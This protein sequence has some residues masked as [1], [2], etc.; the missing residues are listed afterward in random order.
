MNARYGEA[1]REWLVPRIL[2]Y[3]VLVLATMGLVV[4]ASASSVRGSAIAGDAGYFWKRQLV[5]LGAGLAAGWVASLVDYR[6]WRRWAWPLAGVTLLL[7]VLVVPLGPR[8]GGSHRWFRIGG[9]SFQ[10]SE[11]AKFAIVV[12]LAERMSGIPLRTG[13]F[14]EGLLWPGMLLA[15]AVLPIMLEPDVGTSLLIGAV[16]C[17]VLFVGGARF[18]Y[19]A[20]GGLAGLTAIGVYVRMDPVRWGRVKAWLWPDQ[21]PAIAY[22]FLESRNAFILGGAHVNLGGS[23]QKHLYLPEAHTDFVF[24]IL[25]EEFGVW[26]SISVVLFFAAFTVCGLAISMRVQDMFGRLL[27]FGITATIA[28]QAMLN[29][30]VVTGA[31]PTK[32]IPLPFFSYGGSSLVMTLIQVGVLVNV[33]YRA[34][35][36]AADPDRLTRDRLHRL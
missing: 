30:A 34:A 29:I 8:I 27:A 7:L 12:L 2:I 1:D 23:I 17:A 18:L 10:P 35:R 4:L 16:G 31:V 36:E 28:L 20:A 6:R 14:R 5:W 32:G 25:G 21:Y 19:L 11:L 22:H 33:G 15:L 3:A 9:F 13:R 24:A 26:G